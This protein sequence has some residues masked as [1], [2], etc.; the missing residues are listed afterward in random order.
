MAYTRGEKTQDTSPVE[1]DAIVDLVVKKMN[2]VFKPQPR[3]QNYPWLQK[4]YTYGNCAR[5]HPTS[6]CMLKP[7]NLVQQQP[8]LDK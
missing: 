7:Q 3:Q 8:R 6:H 4:P 2:K 1:A 5:D